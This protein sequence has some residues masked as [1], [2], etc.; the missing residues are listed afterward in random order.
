MI[1]AKTKIFSTLTQL[2]IFVSLFFNLAVPA[3]AFHDESNFPKLANYY[4][5]WDL[6][7]AKIEELQKW[8]VVIISAGA[9][10]RHPELVKKLR[11][12]NPHIS[13]LVYIPSQ[14]IANFSPTL[15]DGNVWKD[16][17]NKVNANDWWL[18]TADHQKVS[19]WP[20]TSWINASSSAKTADGLQFTDYLA[21][22]VVSKFLNTG[23]FEGVFYDN[24]FDDLSWVGT[25]IDIDNN[26]LADST[27]TVDAR[28]QEGMNKLIA[29][30]KTL[31]PGKFVLANEKSNFYNTQLNGK[32]REHFPGDYV[33]GWKEEMERYINNQLAGQP[34]AYII[35]SDTNNINNDVYDLR[36]MR[37]TYGSS[38]LGNGYYS[39]DAGDQ[40][41]NS[42]WW[43]DEYNVNL[44][45][46]SGGLKNIL[47]GGNTLGRGV[48]VREFANGFVYLNTMESAQTVTLTA[49]L[50]KIKGVQDPAINNGAIVRKITLN[51]DDAIILQ[52]RIGKIVDRPFVN[53]SFV[54]PFSHDG[55]TLDRNGFFLFNSKFL[56]STQIEEVDINGDGQREFIVGDK[57][58]LTIY[59]PDYSVLK[60]FYPFG[61]K[62]ISGVT[63]GV[64]DVNGDGSL[65]I[66]SVTGKGV[67]AQ[68]KIFNTNGAELK[69]FAPYPSWYKGGLSLALA[70]LNRVAGKEIVIIASGIS[71]PQIK[72]F[73]NQ[74]KLVGVFTAYDKSYSRGLNVAAADLNGDGADEII[75]GT[76]YGSAPLV[77]MFDSRGKS[78]APAFFAA[79]SKSRKGVQVF[80]ADLDS[81]GISEIL[82]SVPTF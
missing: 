52:K 6:T 76:A 61:Q 71:S 25:N 45:A 69:S 19:T 59:A 43:Y 63:F 80:S 42:R 33:H 60:T 58:K 11:V 65:E 15:E 41:H 35:N 44:G 17:Y 47:T 23:D 13:L 62:Y 46:P 10:S 50:E 48:W 75:T 1:R 26:G 14:E 77:K 34:R 64:A 24:M 38:L 51:P 82:T 57:S 5:D 30:T 68:A 31:A 73:S 3:N 4:L 8:D 54:R 74:G 9:Y 22:T 66:V 40:G 32:L 16:I 55:Q 27:S 20:G 37:F 28:W 67:S 29:A 2:T 81:D 36:K 18:Y 7:E 72:I 56:G 39:F 53:G 49:D 21:Q 79:D 70:E 78:F 12:L